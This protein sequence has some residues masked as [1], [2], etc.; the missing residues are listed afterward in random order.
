MAGGRRAPSR[1]LVKVKGAKAKAKKA[2][3]PS[4]GRK[5]AAASGGTARHRSSA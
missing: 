5:K 1:R 3:K 4:G 2:A